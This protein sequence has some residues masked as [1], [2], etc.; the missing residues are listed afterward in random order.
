VKGETMKAN[1]SS[2]QAFYLR[3]AGYISAVLGLI[4]SGSFFLSFPQ[5][6]PAIKWPMFFFGILGIVVSYILGRDV[7]D[8][9]KNRELIAD[10]VP[11][12]QVRLAQVGTRF[13]SV[14]WFFAVGMILALLFFLLLIMTDE[15][16][17]I[18]LICSDP[19][20]VESCAR[21]LLR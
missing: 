6:V 9:F 14:L 7:L 10:G 18:G 20:S 8:R 11:S 16:A 1:G 3:S 13:M 5:D 2:L 21:S 12:K 19:F 4:S 17:I 15:Y